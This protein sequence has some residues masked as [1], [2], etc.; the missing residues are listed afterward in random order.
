MSQ[1]RDVLQSVKEGALDRLRQQLASDPKLARARDENGVSALL[2]ARY[3]QRFDMVEAILEHRALEVGG[4]EL[5]VFEAAA[6]GRVDRLARLIAQEPRLAE[7][8]APDGFTPLQLASF[9]AAPEAVKLLL[10]RGAGIETVSRNANRL[11]AL[12]SAAAGGSIEI[13]ER[14]LQSGADPNA[15]HQG[16]YAPLHTAAGSG[17]LDMVQVLL[18]HGAD[19]TARTDDGKTA[20]DLASAR[21]TAAVVQA[22]RGE[23]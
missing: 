4:E 5:D 3:R 22:L 19:P 1:P 10:Q 7:S 23:W 12:H 20:Y 13:V 6:L 21:G 17:R 18:A 16:G 8:F 14:L 11:R 15:S 9:F 2:Q